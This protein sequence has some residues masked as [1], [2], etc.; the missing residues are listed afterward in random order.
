MVSMLTTM[1]LLAVGQIALRNLFDT[2][3]SWGDPLLRVMVLWIA[4]LGAM[5]ATRANNHIKIDLLSRFLSDRWIRR[6]N[7]LTHAFAAVICGIISWHAS[8]FVL[9][10]M[11][12]G[13]T[14][15]SDIPAWICELIIPIAFALMAL[16]LAL[17]ALDPPEQKQ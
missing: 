5:A 11:E 3:V 16:R 4:L 17:Q 8:R 15:F 13:I 6:S 14:L 10:E 7:R 1:I 2:S 12:D 9:F